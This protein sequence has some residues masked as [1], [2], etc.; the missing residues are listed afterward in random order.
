M[1]PARAEWMEWGDGWPLN[2]AAWC[3]SDLC[4]ATQA[5]LD[6]ADRLVS[7]LGKVLLFASPS[8]DLPV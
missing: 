4:A 3:L 5:E 1:S 7:A 2:G 6:A 8:I